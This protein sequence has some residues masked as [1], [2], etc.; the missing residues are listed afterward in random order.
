MEESPKS[1]FSGIK[2]IYENHYKKLLILPFA[3]LLAAIIFIGYHFAAT[4]EII[5]RDISLKGGVTIT[6]S[7]GQDVDIMALE[8][9]LSL[10]FPDNDLATKSISQFGKQTGFIVEADIS[11]EQVNALIGEIGNALSKKLLPQDYAVEVVGSS[12]GTSFFKELS[13][14]LLIAF[15]FMSLV[16]FIS[17]R[18]FIPS[19]A[20]IFAA[21][22]DM[23]VT[24]AFVNLFGMK[25][26]A[27]GIA[28]FLMLIGYS[29]DT[30]ILLTTRV[31]KRKEETEMERIYGAIKT[32]LMMS[33]TA[34]VAA[35]ATLL[36]TQSEVIRQIMLILLIG[37]LADL[38]YT[39]MQNVGIL[40]I[41]A[42]RKARKRNELQS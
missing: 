31:L 22:S 29:V 12:L 25:I 4:G 23:I 11:Q 28:A 1:M 19:I 15:V 9:A 8:E 41:Y 21:F 14:A 5:S 30:N 33:A 24:L 20:V 6:V 18:T 10:K 42:E 34:I 17:F 27:A 37:L 35:I 38:I 3:L 2:N 32:G 16:V 13:I 39:W 7:S 26:S 40:R 36:V